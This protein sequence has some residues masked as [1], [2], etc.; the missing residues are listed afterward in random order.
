[1]I[2][3]DK[4][5]AALDTGKIVHELE[6]FIQTITQAP[7]ITEQRFYTGL[8]EY[9]SHKMAFVHKKLKEV[10]FANAQPEKNTIE[11]NPAACFWYTVYQSML[12]SS[13]GHH[14][15]TKE[16]QK[17]DILTVRKIISELTQQE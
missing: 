13:A 4:F 8:D 17:N 1:M 6:S 3:Y 5:K 14:A 10:G 12:F 15:P 7:G 2:K 16:R 11:N 9:V